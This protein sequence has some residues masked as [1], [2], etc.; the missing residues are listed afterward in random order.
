LRG[1][2]WLHGNPVSS[3]KAQILRLS[4]QKNN[5]ILT[6]FF[7][8]GRHGFLGSASAEILFFF[9]SSSSF[10]KPLHGNLGIVMGAAV[11]SRTENFSIIIFKIF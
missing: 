10:S 1:L 11:A 8:S 9:L 6:R 7:Q 3:S 4:I 2:P 5:L